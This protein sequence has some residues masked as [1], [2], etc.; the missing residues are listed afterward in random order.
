MRVYI[1]IIIMVVAMTEFIANS[2]ASALDDMYEMM[3]T[4]KC[5]GP[6]DIRFVDGQNPRFHLSEGHRMQT[7]CQLP[8]HDNTISCRLNAVFL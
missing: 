2:L 7:S 8:H 5:Q 6:E 3:L 4:E 1:L